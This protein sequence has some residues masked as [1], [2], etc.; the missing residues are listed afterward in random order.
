MKNILFYAMKNIYLHYEKYF[1]ET[2]ENIFIDNMRKN[3]Y[4][5]YFSTLCKIFSIHDKSY[6]DIMKHDK[7][8]FY[9]AENIFA[10]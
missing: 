10:T 3:Q 2:I 4:E 9:T 6:F 1:I 8:I 5:N 7:N